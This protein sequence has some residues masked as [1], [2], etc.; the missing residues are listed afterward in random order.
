MLV[1]TYTP[2]QRGCWSGRGV[3][4]LESF[5]VGKPC[6]NELRDEIRALDTDKDLDEEGGVVGREFASFFEGLEYVQG[7]ADSLHPRHWHVIL[8]DE[9]HVLQVL[10]GELVREAVQTTPE[11]HLFS[12]VHHLP[13]AD[14][15]NGE[16]KINKLPSPF[17]APTD[18]RTR[19]LS[20]DLSIW[21]WPPL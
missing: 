20:L 18:A 19:R 17:R 14:R 5:L 13:V 12:S 1:W 11:L 8:A 21:C 15:A 2:L 6:R 3:V 7:A 9:L 4:S 10:P 16:G